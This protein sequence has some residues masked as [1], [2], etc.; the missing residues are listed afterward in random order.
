MADL[1]FHVRHGL[2]FKR[3]AGGSVL[4]TCA[5]FSFQVSA[6]E[7]ASVV[8][9]VSEDGEDAGTHQA[10]LRL[11]NGGRSALAQP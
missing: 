1:G 5:A 2:Y 3:M 6:A 10:A 11:H 4:V 9:A 8:A 7:W